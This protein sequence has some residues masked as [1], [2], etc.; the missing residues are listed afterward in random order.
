MRTGIRLPGF[1]VAAALGTALIT[2]GCFGTT[3]LSY[4]MASMKTRDPIKVTTTTHN[5]IWGLVDGQ[6]YIMG[7]ACGTNGVATVQVEH[8]LGDWLY[9]VFTAGIY[10]R[11]T[12]TFTC[13]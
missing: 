10:A 8:T 2:T 12:V 6:G 7:A 1:L 3:N 13:Q 4:S 11:T 9:F 5:W